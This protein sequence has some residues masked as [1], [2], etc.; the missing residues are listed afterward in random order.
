MGEEVSDTH[1]KLHGEGTTAHTPEVRLHWG[2]ESIDETHDMTHTIFRLL[3]KYRY[4]NQPLNFA[5]EFGDWVDDNGTTAAKNKKAD[6]IQS[7]WFG[8]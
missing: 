1:F 7:A 4:L 5:V 2:D 8:L 6:F 3:V